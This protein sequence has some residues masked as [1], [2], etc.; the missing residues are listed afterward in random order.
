MV[1]D[2]LLNTS[3]KNWQEGDTIFSLAVFEENIE[4]LL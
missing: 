1:Q 2:W 4:V 3:T